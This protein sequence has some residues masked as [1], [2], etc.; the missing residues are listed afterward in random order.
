LRDEREREIADRTAPASSFAVMVIDA[1]VPA[2]S[3]PLSGPLRF[4]MIRFQAPHLQRAREGI[5]HLRVKQIAF[6]DIG[7]DAEPLGIGVQDRDQ[8]CG[9]PVF[10]RAEPAD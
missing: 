7:C 10:A 3:Q 8:W 9:N 2:I 6:E 5:A 1:V 4:V